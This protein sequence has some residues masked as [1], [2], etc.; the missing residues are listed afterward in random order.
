MMYA[1][2]MDWLGVASGPLLAVELLAF[3]AVVIVALLCSPYDAYERTGA[4]LGAS[5][6]TLDEHLTRGEITRE[7]YIDRRK[8]LDFSSAIV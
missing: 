3:C 5:R 2:A 8:A 6:A 4:P 7:E 1:S